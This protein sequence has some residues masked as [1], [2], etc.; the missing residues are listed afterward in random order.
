MPFLIL[1]FYTLEE[2]PSV[3]SHIKLI[4]NLKRGTLI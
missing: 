1:S 2:V 4:N 3:E